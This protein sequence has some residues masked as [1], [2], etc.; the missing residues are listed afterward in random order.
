MSEFRFAPSERVLAQ[1]PRKPVRADGM[2]TYERLLDQIETFFSADG[3]TSLSL[4]QI[5]VA[6]DMSVASVYHFFPVP[7][8]ALAALMERY[9]ERAA[10][11]IML[12]Q[13]DDD[14]E[15]W[16]GVVTTVMSRGRAFYEKYPAALKLGLGLV[17]CAS[18]RHLLLESNWA[19][20]ET[21]F[22]ELDRLFMLPKVADLV[23]HFAYA[24]VI[25]DALWSL[26]VSLHGTIT[27][28]LASAA[29]RAVTGYLVPHLGY[30]LRSKSEH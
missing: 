18:V 25:S 2:V 21:I 12:N 5:A 10:T 1:L 11:E 8:A 30:N 20:A 15:N 13:S 29:E 22:A 26:S 28:D 27:D 17:Q 9:L 3:T 14:G 7:E 6:T 23:D 16:Q 24:I 4:K 19:L